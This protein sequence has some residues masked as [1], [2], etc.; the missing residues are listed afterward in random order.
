MDINKPGTACTAATAFGVRGLVRAF[1]RR[2]VA[3]EWKEAVWTSFAG[4]LNAAGFGD[5]SPKQSKR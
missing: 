3:V 4:P 5:K 1:G 2:L